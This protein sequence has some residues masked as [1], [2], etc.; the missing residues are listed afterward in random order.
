MTVSASCLLT[1]LTDVAA[2]APSPSFERQRFSPYLNFDSLFADAK[3]RRHH[4]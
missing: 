2:A 1:P 3:R 4:R